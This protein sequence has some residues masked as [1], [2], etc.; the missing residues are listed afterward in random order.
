MRVPAAQM[1][2]LA[3]DH[4]LARFA[5]RDGSG[6]VALEAELIVR[7]SSGPAPPPRDPGR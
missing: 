4:L 3:A 5:G 2:R 6:V 1:G 7:G